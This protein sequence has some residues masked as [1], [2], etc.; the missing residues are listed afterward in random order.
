MSFPAF[1]FISDEVSQELPVVA[2]FAR[3]FGLG[4]FELRSFAGRAFK[5]LTAADVAAVRAVVRAEGW[6]VVGC[7]SPVFKCALDDA[8]EIARV[9]DKVLCD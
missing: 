8:A 5:D 7:A 2:R 4:G 9:N 1:T 3:E 6:R